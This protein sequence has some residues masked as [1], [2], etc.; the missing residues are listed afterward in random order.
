MVFNEIAQEFLNGLQQ[1]GMSLDMFWLH[2]EPMTISD[3]VQAEGARISHSD[4]VAAGKR[5]K[6]EDIRSLSVPCSLTLRSAIEGSARLAVFLQSVSQSVALRRLAV[7]TQPS[8]LID[9]IAEAAKEKAE[10]TC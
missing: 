10:R 9:E 7:T 2:V 3:R 6:Q 8:P 5:G 1:Q 4:A